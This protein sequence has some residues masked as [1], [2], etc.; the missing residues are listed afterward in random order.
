MHTEGA[1]KGKV[2]KGI[3]GLKGQT[4]STCHNA[5]DPD[6]GRGAAFETNSGS[7]SVLITFKRAKP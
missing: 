7:G 1:L 5:P 2:W 6:K 3:D 4:L